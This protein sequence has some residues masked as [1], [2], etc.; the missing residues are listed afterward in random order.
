MLK[1]L[2]AESAKQFDKRFDA[3]FL[4]ENPNE[5]GNLIIA[6]LSA[7]ISSAFALGEQ[8]GIQKAVEAAKEFEVGMRCAYGSCDSKCS[9]VS[10]AI[11]KLRMFSD[12]LQS[13]L[14]TKKD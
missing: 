9:H 14:T 8:S 11:A 13:N 2:L 3:H 12:A 4:Y 5:A 7:R 1:D 10:V 6:F